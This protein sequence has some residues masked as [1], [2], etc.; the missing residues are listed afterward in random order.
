MGFQAP[1]SV[2]ETPAPGQDPYPFS[3]TLELTYL[4][5]SALGPSGLISIYP[6][7]V[8]LSGSQ[9]RLIVPWPPLSPRALDE[10]DSGYPL[11]SP[12]S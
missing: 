4:P 1:V 2:G 6:L 8:F 10:P 5:L 11:L 7:L 3:L 12:T 9:T